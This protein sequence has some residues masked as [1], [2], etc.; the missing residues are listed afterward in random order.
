MIHKPFPIYLMFSIVYIE[1]YCC[2][3]I[4]IMADEKLAF[5]LENHKLNKTWLFFFSLTRPPV[6][7]MQ[8]AWG[9]Q[10]QVTA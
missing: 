5:A 4:F 6:N 2:H 9:H 8:K 10:G 1:T 7:S 3:A